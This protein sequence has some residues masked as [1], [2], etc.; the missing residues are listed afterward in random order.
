MLKRDF[1]A[2]WTFY[3]KDDPS[4][5]KTVR[6]PY[7]AMRHEQRIPKLK[8]GSLFA[9][10]PSGDYYYEKTLF[11]EKE[12]EGKTV[13]LEFEGIYMQSHVY[14]NGEKV[15]G[16]VY[17][18]TDFFVDITDKLRIGEENEIKVFV[19]NSQV[20]NGRW[21]TGSGIYRP[22]KLIVGNREHIIPDEVKI[23]TESINPAVLSVD[24]KTT[25]A[26]NT[27]VV[28]EIY[29]KDELVASGEGS[30]C[31]ITVPDAKLWDAENPN[32]YTAKVKLLRGDELLDE[33]TH[34]IGIRKLEWSAER[35]IVVN[36]KSVK[37]RGGCVHQDNGPLGTEMHET[38][39]KRRVRIMK[40]N[41]FNAIR[42]AHDPRSREFF[43]ACD[44]IGMYVM[45]EAFDVWFKSVNTYGY[46]LYFREEWEKDLAAMVKKA[47][48]HPSVIMYS[49]GN[50]ISE[51]QTEEGVEYGKRMVALC[52]E[53]DSSRP[54]TLGVNLM[55]NVLDSMGISIT[56]NPDDGKQLSKDD[57]V[58]PKSTEPDTQMGGSVLINN[59]VSVFKGLMM[60]F[61]KPK[62]TDKA[63]KGIFSMVDIAGYNY[64]EGSYEKHHEWHPDR[65]IVGSETNTMNMYGRWKLTEKLPYVV[66]DFMW[67]GWDYLGEC[68]VGVVDY[69]ESTG[70]YS[71]PYPC[72]T[73]GC[74][75]HDMIGKF[76]TI[77]HHYAVIWG[78][79]RK[80]YIAVRH[81]ELYA[82]KTIYAI[83]RYTDAIDSWSFDGCEG[84]PTEV[85]VYSIGHYVKLYINGKCVGKKK[86]KECVAKFKVKYHP[87]IIEAVSYDEKGKEIARDNLR[88][89]S[90]ESQLTVSVENEIIAKNGDIGYID[91]YVTDKDS[92]VRPVAVNVRVEAE[93]A[94]EL[95]AV[96]SGNPRTEDRFVS[97]CYHTYN[98]RMIAIVRSGDEAGEIRVKVSADGFEPKT[99]I[100]KVQ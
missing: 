65:I 3:P 81:P 25:G 53:L 13:I 6:L 36:G 44:E 45:E 21:Y 33:E 88:S 63:T 79:Y 22:V 83:Y 95:Y 37:L 29:W 55:L 80:P 87:G 48:N 77:G 42:A 62:P 97:D 60:L 96:G 38:A 15:G 7:D 85:Q 32:L 73:A 12:F 30:H 76:D 47:R 8:N 10:F 5:K 82:Q 4:A 57:V 92:I 9:F 24:V 75:V 100:V 23:T 93:G 56:A 94:G 61:N 70:A 51:T 14:L 74:G 35:G 86:L 28:T 31:E 78:E 54:V 17:G 39:E 98:G 99:V 18:Y 90:G 11:G 69:G 1:N 19:N 40:Q 43:E 64:C 20:P 84:K 68:G 66:G 41:G 52:H 89:A 27:K 67:T 34:K 50:E 46:S 72:L 91:V 2:N 26:E 71:K 49:I 59:L 16:Q 58:D